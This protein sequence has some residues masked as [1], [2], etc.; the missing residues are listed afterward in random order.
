MFYL[1]NY[2]YAAATSKE[3]TRQPFSRLICGESVAVFR[4]EDGRPVIIGNRCPH[5]QAELAGGQLIGNRIQCPYHGMQFDVQSGKCV[6]IPCQDQ[7]PEKA[8]VRVYP[9][10]ERGGRVWIWVGDPSKADESQ[11]PDLW[12]MDHPEWSSFVEHLEA[13]IPWQLMADNLL[14]FIHVPFVHQKTIGSGSAKNL[15]KNE[16]LVENGKVRNV[17]SAR[18]LPVAPVL[19]EWGGF[20]SNIDREAFVEWSP[21]N[22]VVSETRTT[23]ER[24]VEKGKESTIFMR[25]TWMLTPADEENTHI[26]FGGARNF[27]LGDA[28]LDEFTRNATV[29]AQDEDIAVI[30]GQYKMLKQYKFPRSWSY[31]G[32]LGVDACHQ[33]LTDLYR[34][35]AE[36]EGQPFVAPWW[37]LSGVK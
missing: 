37:M 18:D 12:F 33:L 29:V 28:K 13:P 5:R 35:Q 1:K 26:S 15:A 23:N 2:W 21:P 6:Y 22:R 16:F 25:L 27:R 4:G 11:L 34:R 9:A 14:D 19:R 32:D 24:H 10:A 20:D 3:V 17:M 30:K 31:D 7:I 36:A 8:R